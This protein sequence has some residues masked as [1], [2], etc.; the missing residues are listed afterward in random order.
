MTLSGTVGST[1][2]WESND[3][4][5]WTIVANAGTTYTYSG[6][7]DTTQYRFIASNGACGN[8]TSNVVTINVDPNLPPDAGIVVVN[9]TSSSDTTV[10]AGG[11]TD[12][13]RLIDMVG[14]V[15]HWEQSQ[16]GEIL[17]LRSQTRIPSKFSLTYRQQHI[18]ER[19]FKK[20]PAELDTQ[21]LLLFV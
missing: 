15:I 5:G 8:D 13:L 10:C 6:L 18:I 14:S 11:N 9:N 17:G 16:D 12:T 1:V 19:L 2:A 20:E 3:G 7:L 4:S 21:I